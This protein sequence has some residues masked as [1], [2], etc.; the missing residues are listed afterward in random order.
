MLVL[1]INFFYTELRYP[2]CIPQNAKHLGWLKT[3]SFRLHH[4]KRSLGGLSGVWHLVRQILWK[5][6]L[7]TLQ[8]TRG[9]RMATASVLVW[10]GER[11]RRPWR[12][13]PLA[14]G[15][16]GSS[17][18]KMGFTPAARPSFFP[19]FRATQLAV[20]SL[21]P[22]PNPTAVLRPVCSWSLSLLI[23]AAA[24]STFPLF[25]AP[26]PCLSPP[27]P[28]LHALPPC[29]HKQTSFAWWI[30]EASG[31]N[32]GGGVHGYCVQRTR[33]GFPLPKTPAHYRHR[34]NPY[35]TSICST[36]RSLWYERGE[37]Q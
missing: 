37:L 29:W 33:G 7:Q 16:V 15:P 22:Q 12:V 36:F 1:K 9:T 14:T 26:P 6:P 25:P 23:A 4:M 30:D 8:S 5:N 21:P 18:S 20:R 32:L 10:P 34:T 19:L 3:T 28:H 31:G 13:A 11:P 35:L 2:Y 27:C 24:S 17:G